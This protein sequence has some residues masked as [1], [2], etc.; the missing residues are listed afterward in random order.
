MSSLLSPL[1]RVA[2]VLRDPFWEMCSP[3]LAQAASALMKFGLSISCWPRTP[4]PYLPHSAAVEK[5]MWFDA[6]GAASTGEDLAG[7]AR[8]IG[9][10]DLR[11]P[12]V[13]P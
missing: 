8:A 7:A 12:R 2:V 6:M 1:K 11:L 10:A 5:L 13:G 4:R 3:L 9:L